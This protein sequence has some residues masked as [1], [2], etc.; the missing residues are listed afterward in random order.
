[1]VVLVRSIVLF[2]IG[3]TRWI[4]HVLDGLLE[5]NQSRPGAP[6]MLGPVAHFSAHPV[7]PS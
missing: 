6:G 7:A 1:M 4:V 5:S 3:D 2:A